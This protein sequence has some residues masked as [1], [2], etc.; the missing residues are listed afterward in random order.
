MSKIKICSDHQEYQTPL[1]WTYAFNYA[2]YWCPYCGKNEGMMGAGYDVE[3][4]EELEARKKAYSE[5]S[6]DYLDAVGT[7]VCS[8]LMWEGQRISPNDLPQHEKDRLAE[9]VRKGWQR[10]KP[11][12]LS[13]TE[14]KH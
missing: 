8:S 9:I 10:E 4:T 13:P 2:E 5:A 6:A 3:S 7:K 11:I 1:I 14:S 12:E